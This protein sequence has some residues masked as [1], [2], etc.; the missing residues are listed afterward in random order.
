MDW[1]ESD[2]YHIL[3]KNRDSR[4][5]EILINNILDIIKLKK[6][7]KVLDLAC[8]N[9][10]HSKYLEKLGYKVIGIDNSVNNIIKAKLNEN[11]NLR[12]YNKEMTEYFGNE[13]D[14]VFNLFTSFGYEDEHHNIKTIKNIRDHLKING[15]AVIDYLNSMFIEKNLVKKETKLINGINFH[16][17]RHTDINFIYKKISFHDKKDYVFNEKVMKLKQNDFENYFKKNNLTLIKSFGDY[18]LNEFDINKSERLIMII[19]KSQP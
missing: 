2:Y 11:K 12:F 5:A 6:G 13:F 14:V 10:R 16:I 15:F 9:G 8:G 1:F 19:K 17:E 4:E 7:S 3:Y 18:N